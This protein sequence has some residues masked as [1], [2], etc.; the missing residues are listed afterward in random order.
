MIQNDVLKSATLI[1]DNTFCGLNERIENIDRF[2]ESCVYDR[3]NSYLGHDFIEGNGVVKMYY[4][5]EKFEPSL[6]T[7]KSFRDSEYGM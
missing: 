1:K 3:N 4:T 7:N 2:L 5:K 6:V